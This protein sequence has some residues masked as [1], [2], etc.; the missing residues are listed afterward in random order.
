MNP[1]ADEFE[2]YGLYG[3]E[4][5]D[6]ELIGE[7]ENGMAINPYADEFDQCGLYGCEDDGTPRHPNVKAGLLGEDKGDLNPFADDFVPEDDKSELLGDDHGDLNPFADD[8]EKYGLYGP[9]DDETEEPQMLGEDEGDLNPYA[10]D[11]E[12]YGLYG[13][14]DV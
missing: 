1:N 8:F 7:D 3:K 2:Q 5:D 11:F 10:D 6:Q 4:D 12:K 14:D 9:E 13:K